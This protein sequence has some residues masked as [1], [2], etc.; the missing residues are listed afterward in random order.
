MSAST[1]SPNIDLLLSSFLKIA[2]QS[3]A[4]SDSFYQIL[5]DTYPRLRPLFANTDMEKQKE[6]LMQ[7]LSTVM[8]SVRNPEAF[9]SILKDLGKRHVQYG[10][11]LDDYPLI[12][13]ALLQALEKHLGVDWTPAVKETWT[14]AYQLIA[15]TMTAGVEDAIVE[16][17]NLR[18]DR[19]I[20][21]AS[22]SSKLLLIGG[23]AIV[24]ICG[25]A[26]WHQ[27]QTQPKQLTPSHTREFN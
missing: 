25:Y 8:V 11:V 22:I 21:T 14:Q 7:S 13:D 16:Q 23:L 12:G 20:K 26:F 9:T 4:F 24:A 1:P 27:V 18:I 3:Q 19:D 6:K 2:S 5:L 17:K 15:N 10:T